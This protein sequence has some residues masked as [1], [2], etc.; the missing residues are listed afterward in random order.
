MIN[1]ND[2][3][4]ERNEFVSREGILKYISDYDIFKH[5]I[6]D[7]IVGGIMESPLREKDKTPSF[8][9]F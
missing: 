5:Y 6:G 3:K 2:S 8:G 7:F 1:I 9:I 4:Y